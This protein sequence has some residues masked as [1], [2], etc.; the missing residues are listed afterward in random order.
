VTLARL[1]VAA[2]TPLAPDEA[3]YWVW[4]KALAPGYLDHPPMIALWIRAGTWLV[5][6]TALGIRL[7]GPMTAALGSVLLV[8]AGNDL[9]PG[10]S[11]GVVAAVLLNATLLCGVGSVTATPDT[12]LL[13]FWTAALWALARAFATGRGGWWLVAGAAAG[14]ALD[15][16][17]TAAL[18]TPAVLA[19]LLAVP[20]LR[21]WLRRPHPWIAAA[22]ALLL[23]LPVVT[24]NAGHGWASFV[25][26]GG[27][28][29]DW[30][31]A[32]AAQF[33]SELIGGQIG[34]ATPLIAVLLGGGIVVAAR[35]AWR[36]DPA[37]TLLA[38][39]TLIPAAAFVQ[40]AVGDR[41][42]A[43]WPS[44]MYPAASVAAAGLSG[45][46]VRLRAPAVGLGLAMTVLVWLQG[47]AAPLALPMQ[48]DPTLLRVGGW[49][50]LAVA[51]QAAARREGAAFVVSD[52][53]GHAALLARLLPADIP[54][55]SIDPRWRLFDLRDATPMIVGRTGL[56][57]RSAR[58]DDSPAAADWSAIT[59]LGLLSRS[60]GRMTA[61][62]FRLYRVVG[63]PGDDPIVVMPRPR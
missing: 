31:P 22:L 39:L 25:K 12:P 45:S 43:N 35:R 4:S 58:R 46:W 30:Q 11:A 16:K 26:Q 15:S 52:N 7:F 34:F 54:V 41:V 27:R 13:F 42:Q 8:R 57:L 61:E 18:L 23:F 51:L 2:A 62:A 19:W 49:E 29:G 40:H 63:R 55:L 50:A 32:R 28:S 37:W 36:G 56:L 33:L 1:V 24:W 14:L 53:Y 38:A 20:S 21:P 5:G 17:Y 10:R 60:R 47:V 48:L 3:Y 59:P 6:D 44:V 9:L